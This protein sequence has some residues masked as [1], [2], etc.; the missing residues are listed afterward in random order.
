[1]CLHWSYESSLNQ[2]WVGRWYLCKNTKRKSVYIFAGYVSPL[3][4]QVIT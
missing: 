1:M 3:N 2:K 4:V